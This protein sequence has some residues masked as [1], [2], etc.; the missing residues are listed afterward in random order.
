MWIGRHGEA[1]DTGNVLWRHVDLA[2]HGRDG[3]R[4]GVHILHA[5][6]ADPYRSA[7]AGDHLVIERHQ[8]GHVAIR[9]ADH[10][11]IHARHV[12]AVADRPA[13]HRAIKG[14]GGFDIGGHQFIPDELALF[15]RHGLSP[16]LSAYFFSSSTTVK[17]P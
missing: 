3:C 2:A 13:D 5:D 16:A 14:A 10:P 7:S 4:N 17:P 12:A 9:G 11:V 8:T 15:V 6:I 1:P